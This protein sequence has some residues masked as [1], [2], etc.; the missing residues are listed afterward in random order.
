MLDYDV[1]IIGGSS[2]G[3]YAAAIAAANHARVA[4]V[5]P[6]QPH[7]RADY[8]PGYHQT[9]SQVTEGLQRTQQHLLSG[10]YQVTDVDAA[11]LNINWPIAGQYAE[12]VVN[13]LASRYSLESLARVGVDIIQGQGEFVT[14]PDL[15]FLVNRRILRSRRYLLAMGSKPKIP[16]IAGLALTGFLTVETLHK[17][18]EIPAKLAIIGG[19][20]SA[21]ELAQIFARLGTDVTIIVKSSH[22]LGKEDHRPARLIQ[23]HLE[24]EGITV[25]TR[26]EVVQAQLIQGKKWVQAGNKA[27]EVNEILVAAGRQPQ[28]QNLNLSDIGVKLNQGYLSLNQK[29][30][31]TNY[32]IYACGDLAGGYPFAQIAHYEA[33]VCLKNILFFPRFE[34]NY[35]GIPWAIFTDPQLARVGLTEQQARR[36]YGDKVLIWQDSLVDLPKAQILGEIS[37]FYQLIGHRNGKILG[38]SI[39]SPQAS[40]IIGTIALAMRQGLKIDALAKLPQVGLTLSEMNSEMASAWQRHRYQKRQW[41]SDWIETLYQWRRFW[42][43]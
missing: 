22:I 28:L 5:E 39:V 23:A 15:E 37:G 27:L 21:V 7:S 2:T 29:L 25:L 40:E 12:S 41:V 6:L 4:L 24:A 36:Y 34:V 35:Q 17:L 3:R 11:Q 9:L 10:V 14:K 33:E 13:N 20:P 26:T 43:S 38:A 8:H 31:T 42:F 16:E 18:S 19:D 30:Q 32:K 1:V